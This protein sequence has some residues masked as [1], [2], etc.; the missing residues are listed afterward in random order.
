MPEKKK[1]PI[2]KIILIILGALIA[3]GIVVGV[4]VGIGV[5]GEI[6][7]INDYKSAVSE[8]NSLILEYNKIGSLESIELAQSTDKTAIKTAAANDVIKIQE[9]I[10]YIENQMDELGKQKAIT[11]DDNE[12]KELYETLKSK[13]KAF[14]DFYKIAIESYKLK[15]QGKF[16]AASKKMLTGNLKADN[17]FV[18]ALNNLNQ[19]LVKKAN[20]Q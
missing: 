10:L 2:L 1:S 5:A 4:V 20:N 18:V 7:K 9:V 14:M 13:E 16:N 3:A 6:S 12:A 8:A 15:S 19:Y 11:G 17:E